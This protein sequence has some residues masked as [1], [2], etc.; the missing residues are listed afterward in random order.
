MNLPKFSTILSI[1][2][3]VIL[4]S[5]FALQPIS[6]KTPIITSISPNIISPG[7]TLIIKGNNFGNKKGSVYIS[8]KKYPYYGHSILSWTDN[9]I[10]LKTD[11]NDH[12]S[13]GLIAI[14]SWNNETQVLESIYYGP[15]ISIKPTIQGIYPDHGPAGT[16]VDV[17]GSHFYKNDIARPSISIGNTEVDV[18]FLNNSLIQF[19][20]PENAKSGNIKISFDSSNIPEIS[21]PLF[22]VTKQINDTAQISDQW[23]LSAINIPQA[24]TIT[25]GDKKTIVAIIDDGVY[26][27][28]PELSNNIW[29]NTD[30]IEG[31]G[32]DD[33]KNGFT[34]DRWGWN[35]AYRSH[36]MTTSGTH[37]TMVA[38]IIGAYSTTD[39]LITGINKQ[40]QMM[41]LIVSDVN[42][43]IFSKD[44]IDAIYYAVDN[45][46]NIINLSLGGAL[47]HY[48]D[49]FDS[50]IEYAYKNNVVIV[51]AAGNGDVEGGIGRDLG[52]TKISPVCN[53]GNN[54]MIIGVGASDRNDNKTNWSN[55]GTCVDVYA[56]GSAIATTAVPQYSKSGL[57]YEE[58]S[59]TSFSAPM[60][61][62]VTALIKSKYP[63]ISN[64]AVY[65]RIIENGT[66]YNNITLLN[67]YNA[68]NKP[69]SKDDDFTSPTN[70]EP[71]TNTTIQT[72]AKDFIQLE[73]E[74][75]STIDSTLSKRLSGKILLQVQEHG[76]AWYVFPENKKRYY[77]GTAQDAYSIMRK[78]GLGATHDFISSHTIFPE[79]VSG[80]ILLDVELRGEAYYINPDNLK[81][82]YL[83]TPED[84]YEIMRSLGLGISNSDI[85]KI[86]IGEIY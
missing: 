2:T 82:Y 72:Q 44:I 52:V 39:P 27:G 80:K 85:Q 38:G 34:D 19:T 16:Q 17:Y 5:F 60:V 74:R 57:F 77:L 26:L 49:Q 45:G 15:D 56:P 25:T 35:F 42:G 36:D 75:I 23:Y 61:S 10:E 48:T 32:I 33:D 69:Y 13:D 3:S 81:A 46:A 58:V 83:G 64:S 4:G 9:L 68:L 8:Q 86:D 40:V 18:D 70:T 22:T 73:K 65:E 54:N 6:A 43:N 50:V 21:G 66:S 24:H 47:Y 78:L 31:N 37:G 84:A 29:I 62:G 30:E 20:I 11:E 59:G 51:V 28:H 71:K 63:T 41:P 7:E 14:Q 1:I 12:L 67:A 79:Y 55:Y 53:D 76:E